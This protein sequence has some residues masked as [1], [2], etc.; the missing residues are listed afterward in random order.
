MRPYSG[1]G[2]VS[3][4]PSLEP[5]CPTVAEAKLN[6]WLGT[7]S[8]GVWVL[9]VTLTSSCLGLVQGPLRHRSREPNS[10][11]DGSLE[12]AAECLGVMFLVGPSES[13]SFDTRWCSGR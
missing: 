4:P 1:R 11:S 9:F 6:T 8:S 7:I 5:Q 12:E 2:A 10:A 13:S 3:M